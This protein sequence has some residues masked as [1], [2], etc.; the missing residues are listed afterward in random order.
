[1]KTGFG[2]QPQASSG[3]SRQS[4]GSRSSGYSQSRGNIITLFN[5]IDQLLNC[6]YVVYGEHVQ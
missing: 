5:L 2:S 1:M 3:Y 4:F 6:Y